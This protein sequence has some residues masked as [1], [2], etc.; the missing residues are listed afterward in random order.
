MSL[1]DLTDPQ[2]VLAA[3]AE[4]DALGQ[5][6]FLEKHGF[7]PARSY[8]LIHG[9]RRY[10]SKAIAGAAFGFQHPDRPPLRGP[11]FSGGE[12]TVR[13]RLEQLGFRVTRSSAT[14]EATIRSAVD[15]KVERSDDML[16]VAYALSRL[17][18]RRPGRADGPPVWLNVGTWEAAYDLFYARLGAGR[19]ASAFRSS[20][21]NARDVFDPHQP[22]SRRGWLTAQG[23]RPEPAGWARRVMEAWDPR[24]EAEVKAA[25][26]EILERAAPSATAGDGWPDV[27]R[28]LERMT[29]QTVQQSGKLQTRTLKNKELRC[30]DLE[31]TLDELLARQGY[32]CAQTG[33]GFVESDPEL[34]ASLDRI[35][36]DGHYQDGSLGD[37]AHNLQLVTHWYNMA[38]GVRSDAEMR[39]LIAIHAT[40][41]AQADKAAPQ[42]A[43]PPPADDLS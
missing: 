41:R 20:L 28:R 33:V 26:L 37:G 10:D 5:A 3:I 22:T 18:E 15:A 17:G 9:G 40:P 13:R 29:R 25:V 30:A 27:R 38:K 31:A 7:R 24:S 34:R 11:D 14:G 42:P 2:A 12:A 1:S 16:V 36:S 39:R 35:D 21:K 43:P 8:F 19:S 4:Y 23:E 6:A 32:R